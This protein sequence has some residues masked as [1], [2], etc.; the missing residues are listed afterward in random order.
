ECALHL[1]VASERSGFATSS[2]Y[3]YEKSSRFLR[4][5]EFHLRSGAPVAP[6]PPVERI[7]LAPSP[8]RL[9]LKVHQLRRWPVGAARRSLPE[10]PKPPSK[11]RDQP[12]FPPPT[13]RRPQQAPEDKG[14]AGPDIE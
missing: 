7:A 8:H 4:K 5:D 12:H 9:F 14:Q 13:S 2:P 3:S 11:G 6:A 10:S 1:L